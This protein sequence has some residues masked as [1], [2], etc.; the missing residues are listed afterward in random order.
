MPGFVGIQEFLEGGVVRRKG[1]ERW[2]ESQ[3]SFSFDQGIP[4]QKNTSNDERVSRRGTLGTV[5]R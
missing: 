5:P 2:S 4:R 3:N 1:G